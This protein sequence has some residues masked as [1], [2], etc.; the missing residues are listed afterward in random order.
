MRVNEIAARGYGNA[1]EVYERARP[2]YAADAVAWVCERLGIGAGRTVLDLGAGTGKLTRDL[3]STG[4]RLIAVEPVEEMLAKLV[5]VVPGVEALAGTA[6]QLPLAGTSVDAVVSAQAFHWFKADQALPEI[7]R[8]LRPGGA[9]ALLWNSRD[10]SDPIQERID[11]VLEP[12]RGPVERCWHQQAKADTA[13]EGS[14]LFGPVEHRTWPGEQ[15]VTIE[16][17]LEVV[18]SRS[19]V[20]SLEE[21]ERREVLDSTRETVAGESEPILLRYDVDVF[22]ADRAP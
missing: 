15:R 10:L 6:E 5:E 3:V 17:L 4:A 7:H 11:A 22:V 20:A 12:V 16:E 21:P 14:P 18:A 9:I 2:G 1:A 13:L 8:V 19:Y